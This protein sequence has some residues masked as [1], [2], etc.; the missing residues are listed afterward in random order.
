MKTLAWPGRVSSSGDERYL[1]RL[2]ELLVAELLARGVPA[3]AALLVL[4]PF[5]V[6]VLGPVLEED[7][8]VRAAFAALVVTVVLRLGGLLAIRFLGAG[9]LSP[10]QLT[11]AF[12]AGTTLVAVAFAAINL[13]AIPK[14]EGARVA[15]LAVCEA[16]V[17][18][19]GVVSM[20]ASFRVYFAY[21]L[22]I[23]ASFELAVLTT[24]RSPLDAT[25]GAL[26]LLYIGSL[27]AMSLWVHGSLRENYLFRLRLADLATHDPLTGLLNRRALEERMREESEALRRARAAGHPRGV[28]LLL[29]DLDRFKQV[30]DV[31]GHAVGDAVL[32]RVATA[33]RTAVRAPDLVARW[34]GE[35]FVV[36]AADADPGALAVLAERIRRGLSGADPLVSSGGVIVPTCSVGYVAHPFFPDEADAMTWRDSLDLA[37]AALRL[38]KRTGRNRSVGLVPGPRFGDNPRQA[39]GRI[40]ADLERAVA[41]GLVAPDTRGGEP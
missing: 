8:S 5:L 32:G 16:G 27:T 1:A 2:E 9:R 25:L 37:D 26:V 22:P 19:V 36:V 15:L 20:A 34:G 13:V 31:F 39:K 18:T 3:V 11:M 14:L 10:R 17:V 38:A 23:L 7:L 35:E 21:M 33:L 30:N 24:A 29:V 28:G 4:L 12:A 40:D 41:E 6:P